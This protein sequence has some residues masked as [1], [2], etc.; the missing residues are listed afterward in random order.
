[1]TS[2]IE[3]LGRVLDATE[4]LVAAV[5]DDQWSAPTPCTEWSVR[6]LVNH[7]TA[8][9]HL[10]ASALHGHP[11]PVA[12]VAA[13]PDLLG[14]DPAG[15]FHAAA[16]ALVQAFAAPGALDTEVDLPIRRMPAAEAL[17]LRTVEII[18][19]G[20]DLAH[21]TGQQTRYDDA[22]VEEQ[23]AFSRALL[24][25]IPEGRTPFAPPQSVAEDAPPIDRL[26]ALLGRTP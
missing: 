25:H 2:T 18:T 10:F 19:H 4:A 11:L 22:V 9:N 8:G 15:S 20:W 24:P 6:E 7:M 12:A 1:M 26:V 16:D 3:D 14:P 5:A 23:I 17:N 21:A 13:P